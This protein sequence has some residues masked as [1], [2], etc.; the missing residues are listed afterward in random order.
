MKDVVA[1]N[2]RHGANTEIFLIFFMRWTI[3][4]KRGLDV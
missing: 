2:N 3:D 1:Y 4:L